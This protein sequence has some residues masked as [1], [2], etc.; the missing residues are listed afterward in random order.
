VHTDEQSS[1]APIA[2]P[3]AC[4]KMGGESPA[5]ANGYF[6]YP[7]TLRS[8]QQACL[9]IKLILLLD[10]VPRSFTAVPA[11]RIRVLSVRSV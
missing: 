7:R 8:A 6:I 4:E 3:E 9:S 11:M 2:A 1:T 10:A 5:H